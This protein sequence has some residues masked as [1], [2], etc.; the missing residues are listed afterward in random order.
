MNATVQCLYAL[1]ELRAWLQAYPS[2]ASP[3][4]GASEGAHRLAVACKELFGQLRG[5]GAEAVTPARFLAALRQQYPVFA[6]TGPR[7]EAM[8]Q[9]AEE[10]WTGVVGSLRGALGA[11]ARDLFALNLRTLYTARET[12]ETRES[13][14]TEYMLKARRGAGRGGTEHQRSSRQASLSRADMRGLRPTRRAPFPRPTSPPPCRTWRT[15]SGWLWTGR[16]RC[17]RRRLAG[18][19]CSAAPP[20][21]PACRPCSPC[22]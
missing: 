5:S 6:A 4:P 18:T 19:L 1:P 15:A 13:V 20:C 10:C 17:G 7:G 21:S 11:P 16:G 22:S 8:Q 2:G 14:E 9:D 3:P 12:G